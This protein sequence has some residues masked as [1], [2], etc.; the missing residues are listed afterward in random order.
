[1]SPHKLEKEVS[2]KQGDEIAHGH[3]RV[4]LVGTA[5]F[6]TTLLVSQECGGCLGVQIVQTVDLQ[7]IIKPEKGN[8]LRPDVI[9]FIGKS[10]SQSQVQ[11]QSQI[12]KERGIRSLGFPLNLMDHQLK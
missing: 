4:L 5:R 11:A 12:K 3:G 7:F 10:E 9:C 2:G 8:S 1:M 6:V